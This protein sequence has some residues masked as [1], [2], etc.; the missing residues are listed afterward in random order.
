M[1]NPELVKSLRLV[2]TVHVRDD[3]GVTYVFGPDDVEIPEWAIR[4]MGRHCWGFVEPRATGPQRDLLRHTE[5]DG[6]LG[7][8]IDV[9][10]KTRAGHHDRNLLVARF[11]LV[12]FRDV[13][14]IRGQWEWVPSLAMKSAHNG[15]SAGWVTVADG[16]TAYTADG[17]D[18]T[19]T[20]VVVTPDGSPQVHLKCSLCRYD[21]SLP[22]PAAERIF[23]DFHMAGVSKVLLGDLVRTL[24]DSS[25]RK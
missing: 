4:K 6:Q 7:S 19:R 5:R 20:A 8:L 18:D 10:C 13:T 21:I 22:R 9:V 23:D 24:T 1:T 15:A 25:R 12:D 14:G 16:S 2:T 3:A 11:E 17:I